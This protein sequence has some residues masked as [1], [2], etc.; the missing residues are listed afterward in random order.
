MVALCCALFIA[1]ERTVDDLDAGQTDPQIR[2][3]AAVI[4]QTIPRDAETVDPDGR[5]GFLRVLK[6]SHMCDASAAAALDEGTFIAA[7]DERNTLMIYRAGRGGR[8]VQTIA[9]DRHLGIDPGKDEHPEADIEGA[10]MLDGRIFWITS[11]GRN[12]K[13]K[14]RH[15][16]HRFFALTVKKTGDRYTTLPYGTAREDLIHHLV[17]D[18]RTRDLGLAEAYAAGKKVSERLA[19]KREGLNV[20]GLCA[21]ADGRS[22]WIA[23]RNPRPHGKAIIVPLENPV[24]VVSKGAAPQFGDPILLNLAEKAGSQGLGIRSIEYSRRLKAYLVVAGPHHARGEFAIYRWRGRQNDRP[25][26]LRAATAAVAGLK[27]FRPEALI[28]YPESERI[29]LLSDDGA[30]PVRVRSPAECAKGEFANGWCQQKSLNSNKR[31]T[32]RSIRIEAD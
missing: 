22:L 25:Q 15:N 23:L 1:H 16:R 14:W 18:E 9:W 6:Y 8:P 10:A 30:L 24:A 3:H 21:A 28:V 32:F 4:P 27:D 13:G 12:R 29:Q 20:E 31:K 11:H 5:P 7:D 19:P 26:R 17:E 2:Q